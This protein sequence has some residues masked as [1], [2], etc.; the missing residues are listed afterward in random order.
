MAQLPK[1]IGLIAGSGL[2]ALEHLEDVDTRR[3]QTDFGEVAMTS[4]LWAG[5]QVHFITRHGSDHS[6][7]PHL[8]NYRANAQ[9]LKKAGAQAV[10]LVNCVGGIKPDYVRP[11]T[12]CAPDQ[13]LDLTQAR[14]SS[15]FV[16]GEVKHI[17]MTDPCDP[18]LRQGLLQA[19]KAFDMIQESCCYATMQGPRLETRAEIHFLDQIGAHIVGMT[20]MPELP[21]VRELELPAAVISLVVNAAAGRGGGPIDATQVEQALAEGM[22]RVQALIGDWFKRDAPKRSSAGG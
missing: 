8:V 3:I 6:L 12:L 15:F 9:A 17:D 11:G 10:I 1:Q 22:R 7:A 4:G 18:D 21:L 2:Y 16:Q 19:G 20:A 5:R 14:P 13:F